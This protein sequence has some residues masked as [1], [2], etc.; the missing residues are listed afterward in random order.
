M[1][2]ATGVSIGGG[3]TVLGDGDL[4]KSSTG[5]LAMSLDDPTSNWRFF[6]GATNTLTI[7]P[8]GVGIGLTSPSQALDVGKN[9]QNSGDTETNGLIAH[10]L[11]T[12]SLG[13]EAN[14]D[15]S[16]GLTVGH[17]LSVSDGM[18]S[19]GGISVNGSSTFMDVLAA[20]NDAFDI[21]T[22]ANSFDGLYASGTIYRR[23]SM[24]MG[25]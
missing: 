3:T 24:W 4:I 8:S 25:H 19:S 5:D 22:L 6:N 2:S 7:A 11:Q 16:N 18:L 15:I 13:V 12:G 17:S 9:I 20:S 23:N 10:S 1:F 21:G 14:A